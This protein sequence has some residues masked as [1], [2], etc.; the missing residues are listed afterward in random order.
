VLEIK[1]PGAQIEDRS[2]LSVNA[3]HLARGLRE[4]RPPDA[5]VTSNFTG[6]T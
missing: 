2:P 3:L 5:Q 4:G 1:K 6:S